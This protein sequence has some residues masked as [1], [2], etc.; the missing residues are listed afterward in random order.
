MSTEIDLGIIPE[1]TP[2]VRSRQP[3][4]P[5]LALEEPTPDVR[6]QVFAAPEA[7][8]DALPVATP[9]VRSQE[10]TQLT[11]CLDSLGIG[12]MTASEFLDIGIDEMNRSF[13][14]AVRAGAAFWATQE[15][16]RESDD[17]AP[18][19][20]KGW[21]HDRGLSEQRVYE[22]ISMAKFY[23]RL[24][25]GQREQITKIGKSKAILLAGVPQQ[26]MDE[27]VQSGRDV[28]GDADLMTVAELR[29]EIRSLK[30]REANYDAEIER[31]DHLIGKLS[32]S[33]TQLTEFHPRTEDLRAECLI[34]QGTCESTLMALRRMYRAAVSPHEDV[35]ERELQV[36]HVWITLHAIAAMALDAI[37]MIRD[38]DVQ[39]LPERVLSQHLLTPEEAKRWIIEW[40][41]LEGR[42]QA[43]AL[44]RQQQR[45]DARPRGPGRPKKVQG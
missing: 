38:E 14:H 44:V 37:S 45:E 40:R 12:A 30:K 31:R 41:T 24:P 17:D 5:T 27:A 9:D 42:M 4:A 11:L 6:S 28:I 21:L 32:K 8:P 18:A 20:F 25:A 13:A 15:A 23:A 19:T 3:A 36:D 16:L 43:E 26:L 22:L 10:S 39:P 35:P 34:A 33:S 2:H 1:S 29:E 7:T